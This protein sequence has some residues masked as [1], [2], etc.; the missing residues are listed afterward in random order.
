MPSERFFMQEM[1]AVC[2]SDASQPRQDSRSGSKEG[3]S[4]YAAVG[5]SHNEDMRSR[6]L[7]DKMIK[8]VV[9]MFLRFRIMGNWHTIMILTM[10]GSPVMI[11]IGIEYDQ[12]PSEL[13]CLTDI[14]QYRSDFKRVIDA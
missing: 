10:I 3:E 8:D 13:L 7:G 4:A 9:G 2:E 14:G 12:F 1:H 6:R 11:E 5:M